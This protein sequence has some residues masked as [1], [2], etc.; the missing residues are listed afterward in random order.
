MSTIGLSSAFSYVF[1]DHGIRDYHQRI[2]TTFNPLPPTGKIKEISLRIIIVAAAIFAYPLLCLTALTSR[3][4]CNIFLET[5]PSPLPSPADPLPRTD[6]STSSVPS[7]TTPVTSA[8]PTIPTVP[9]VPILPLPTPPITG[10]TSFS[11]RSPVT[12]DDGWEPIPPELL[13][14][15]PP[16]PPT[17]PTGADPTV[18]VSIDP[19]TVPPARP[20]E[21]ERWQEIPD[22][23]LH[24]DL[25]TTEPDDSPDTE[26]DLFSAL[27]TAKLHE[28]KIKE[29]RQARKANLDQ[30]LTRLRTKGILTPEVEARLNQGIDQHAYHCESTRRNTVLVSCGQAL[31]LK[32]VYKDTHYVFFHAQQSD[33]L[34]TNYLMKELAKFFYSYKNLKLFKYLRNPDSEG[35]VDPMSPEDLVKQESFLN[36][37]IEANIDIP[38]APHALDHSELLRKKLLSVDLCD[39]GVNTR[40]GE[41]SIEFLTSNRSVM[42][43]HASKIAEINK[44]IVEEFI[45]R[46]LKRHLP[47]SVLNT[48]ISKINSLTSKIPGLKCGNLYVICIPKKI[49]KNPETNIVYRAHPYGHLCK[50]HA[51]E[52]QI[53]ILNKL[54]NNDT[55]GALC[56]DRSIPQGRILTEHLIPEK[57]VLSFL[58]TPLEKAKRKA[59]KVEIRTYIKILADEIDKAFKIAVRRA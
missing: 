12:P 15:T 48:F 39:I 44:A 10:S 59:T 3:M 47:P 13:Y 6:S 8:I 21:E 54:Q 20:E 34:I 23:L 4:Y 19:A 11:V 37:F 7:P 9:A 50:C 38:S 40:S 49:V 58:V 1:S 29:I 51:K 57:G 2:L 33:F 28:E 55:T 26:E 46:E 16:A 32:A 27:G 56:H 18:A 45:P 14:D 42:T 31:E 25:H 24:P 35:F 17:P 30:E 41:S 36:E 5:R 53:P 22:Y 43:A 52:S